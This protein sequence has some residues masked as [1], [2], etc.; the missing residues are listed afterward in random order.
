MNGQT[1]KSWKSEGLLLETEYGSLVCPYCGV[2]LFE[3]ILR[4]YVC[5]HY[6]VPLYSCATYTRLKR[7]KKYLN[8]S[9]MSQSQ[10]SIP[11]ATWDYLLEELR[12][13]AR[14]Q[15]CADSKKHPREF[16]RSVTTRF[17]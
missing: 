16:E 10:N 4:T 1:C 5:S 14:D 7:F 12:T 13:G 15:S 6:C 17:R 9:T 11:P 3:P 8:R 2:E